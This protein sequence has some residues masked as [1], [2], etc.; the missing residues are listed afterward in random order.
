MV[1]LKTCTCYLRLTKDKKF[2][3]TYIATLISNLEHVSMDLVP[4][5][6]RHR[7]YR[8][9]HGRSQEPS[10]SLLL[11]TTGYH[12]LQAPKLRIWK[13][14]FVFTIPTCRCELHEPACSYSLNVGTIPHDHPPHDSRLCMVH[15]YAQPSC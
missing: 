10:K 12:K 9:A 15:E 3:I 13:C 6:R 14:A 5:A 11:R 7:V 4:S 2:H 1:S 8:M